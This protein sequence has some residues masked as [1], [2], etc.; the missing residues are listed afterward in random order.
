MIVFY[1]AHTQA[2]SQDSPTDSDFE[3]LANYFLPKALHPEAVRR[4]DDETEENITPYRMALYALASTGDPEKNI[5]GLLNPFN[6]PSKIQWHLDKPLGWLQTPLCCAVAN[7][8]SELIK[9]AEDTEEEALEKDTEVN[10]YEELILALLAY[11]ANPNAPGLE[12]YKPMHFV[13]HARIVRIL[14]DA[15][16]D[17]NALTKSN[18]TP[19]DIALENKETRQTVIALLKS[20]GG[21][22]SKNLPQ[23]SCT[24]S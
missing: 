5:H 14:L 23:G 11:G 12:G 15:G 19:L 2:A 7:C 20:A 18:K 13:R 1:A 17:K 22:E 21:L 4:Q 9:T 6:E 3:D 8:G 16:A 24:I 10:N